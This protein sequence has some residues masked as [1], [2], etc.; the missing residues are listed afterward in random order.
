MSACFSNLNGFALGTPIQKCPS[1]PVRPHPVRM[2]WQVRGLSRRSVGV[3]FFASPCSCDFAVLCKPPGKEVADVPAAMPML[4]PPPIPPTTPSVEELVQQ[5]QWN[6][7]QQEQ[8]LLSLR[9][10]RPGQHSRRSCAIQNLGLL[11]LF[12]SPNR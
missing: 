5:S 10:V 2:F 3:M 7:Q 12:C 6:L 4:A 1:V 9:Q 8:H 11:S